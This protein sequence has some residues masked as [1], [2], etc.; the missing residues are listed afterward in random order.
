MLSSYIHIKVFLQ[1]Y[2]FRH[3]FVIIFISVSSSF[4]HYFCYYYHYY[5][6]YY[7][8]HSSS[9]YY[10]LSLLIL[11]FIYFL[12]FSLIF[13]LL[14]FELVCQED[15]TV[16]FAAAHHLLLGTTHAARKL[17]IIVKMRLMTAIFPSAGVKWSWNVYE[18]AQVCVHRTMLAYG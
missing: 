4:Y 6:Y 14:T 11:L 3:F 1:F 8:Y 12:T 10:Y 13:S 17:V 15:Q 16:N 7:Y 9:Y 5:Y 18:D 2:F